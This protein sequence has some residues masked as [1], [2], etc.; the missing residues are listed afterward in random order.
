MRKWIV[1]QIISVLIARQKRKRGGKCGGNGLMFNIKRI[2]HGFRIK[3]T[4]QSGDTEKIYTTWQ[5][6]EQLQAEIKR[7]L[8]LARGSEE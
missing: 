6:L 8:K 2:P 5:N 1:L 3:V 4:Y 7:T